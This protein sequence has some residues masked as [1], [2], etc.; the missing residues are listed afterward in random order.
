MG[1]L[2][3]FLRFWCDV[4]YPW[5]IA[6][7]V[8]GDLIGRVPAPQDVEWLLF[9]HAARRTGTRRRY[10]GFSPMSA[11]G[12]AAS[13]ARRRPC[14]RHQGKSLMPLSRPRACPPSGGTEGAEGMTEPVAP[15]A[16]R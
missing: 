2:S 16:R 12:A 5:R 15:A 7:L 9:A 10:Q 13:V 4:V 8:L 14:D 6:G 1:F 3:G 11:T